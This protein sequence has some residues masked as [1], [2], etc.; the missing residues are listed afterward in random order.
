M[1]APFP[2][3]AQVYRSDFTRQITS[4]GAQ[5]WNMGTGKGFNLIP[6]ANTQVDILTP[7]YVLH[8]DGTPDGFGYVAFLSKFRFFS[9]N[10]QIATYLMMRAMGCT[11]PSGSH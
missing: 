7:G 1:V 11:V 5:N 8:G 4:T 3:L 9:A 6:F 2:M 10:E